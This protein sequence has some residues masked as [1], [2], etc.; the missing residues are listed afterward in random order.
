MMALT[1]EEEHEYGGKD[2]ALWHQQKHGCGGF[3]SKM[4]DYYCSHRKLQYVIWL[5]KN[6]DEECSTQAM[7]DAATNGHFDVVKWLHENRYEGGTTAAM[8]GAASNNRREM[9]NWLHDCSNG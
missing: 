7:D 3:C 8:D 4:I 5:H 2:P 6:C 9:V 1:T